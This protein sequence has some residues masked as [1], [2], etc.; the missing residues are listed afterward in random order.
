MEVK[1]I[2]NVFLLLLALSLSSCATN[3]Y[4]EFYTDTTNGRNILA[5]SYIVP[6]LKQ[7][8]LFRGVSQDEDTQKML[9][10]GYFLIG[11]SQFNTS[12]V[13]NSY[14]LAFAKYLHA[15][16]VIVY[17]R[18]TNTVTEMVPTIIPE[19]KTIETMNNGGG[20]IQRSGF[21]AGRRN[22]RS[23]GDWNKSS[24]DMGA[25]SIV[26]T[27]ITEFDTVFV[28]TAVNQYDY[29]ATYWIQ[30]KP[31]ILGI[32]PRNLSA[33]E[34]QKIGTNKGILILAVI[35]GSPAFNA[36]IFKGD[37]VTK[38]DDQ[39][40][41]DLKNFFHTIV[42]SLQ[43]KTATFTILRNGNTLTKQVQIGVRDLFL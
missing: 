39:E 43:G 38:V 13:R 14:A 11:Y 7:P 21:D 40:V 28:P 30:G 33:D 32:R 29:S 10:D 5:A 36:D 1:V 3:P 18:Y 25:P 22:N 15:A 42:P 6:P 4:Q 31:P 24:H 37:I 23:P 9:E 27:T 16:K 20:G 19:T 35:T 17:S 26:T 12:E 8:Q 34:R 2:K 41:T